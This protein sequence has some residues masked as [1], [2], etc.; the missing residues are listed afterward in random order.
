MGENPEKSPAPVRDVKPIKLGTITRRLPCVHEGPVVEPCKT[1]S[2]GNRDVRLCAHPAPTDPDRDKCTRV[3]TGGP[4]Q[5]CATCVDYT[6]PP[7]PTTGV[8]VSVADMARDAVRLAGM[9]P[10][11]VVGIVGIP[12]SGMIP[13][14]IMATTL[15][16]P[17]LSVAPGVGLIRTGNGGRGHSF[18]P[19]AGRVAVVDDTVYAGGAMTQARHDLRNTPA[20]YCAVYVKPSGRH[21]VDLYARELQSPHLLEWNITNNGPFSGHA[22]NPAYKAGIACD[23]DGIFCHDDKSGGVVGTPYLLPRMHAC[24]LV[25]TGRPERHRAETEAWLQKWGAKVDRLVMYP[26]GEP[27]S[28]SLVAKFKGSVYKESGCGFFLESCPRQA[29]VINAVSGK[30][31]ICPAAGR[32]WPGFRRI[33]QPP[34]AVE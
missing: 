13:A 33:H 4:V 32:V 7:D 31:V 9:L 11:D 16:L 17:L 21:H 22:S 20:V 1:C 28:E 10:P 34:P 8:W 27:W 26:D 2:S 12:R 5:A 3:A 19:R 30:S 15:H 24:R 14:S 6:P 18:Q 23:F 25:V 29:E